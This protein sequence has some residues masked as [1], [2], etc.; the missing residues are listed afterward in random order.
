[1]Q[2]SK[3][4]ASKCSIQLPS[5]PL[6]WTL[7]AVV[8]KAKESAQQGVLSQTSASCQTTGKS[9][10]LTPMGIATESLVGNIG[11]SGRGLAVVKETISEETK[12]LS[13]SKLLIA[14]KA[15]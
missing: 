8:T 9:I 1:M 11:P 5:V 14:R 2:E 12:Q 4:V 6:V 15:S 13:I 7:A 10:R 3:P